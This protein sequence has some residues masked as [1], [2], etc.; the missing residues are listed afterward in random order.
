MTTFSSKHFLVSAL[1]L[2]SRNVLGHEH[3]VPH[4]H[5]VETAAPTMSGSNG[6]GKGM[7]SEKSVKSYGKG[8]GKGFKSSKSEKSKGSKDDKTSKKDDKSFKSDKR[9]KLKKDKDGKL[10]I[11]FPVTPPTPISSDSISSM[12]S[13]FA[14]TYL[15][16]MD[17]TEEDFEELTMVTQKYLE[18]FMMSFFDKTSLTDLDNFL[19]IMTR[20][21]YLG[22]EPFMAIYQSEGRFD[23][24][25]IFIPVDRELDNLI[26]DAIA[27]EEYLEALKDLPRSNPLRGTTSIKLTE[28]GSSTAGDE[29]TGS[30]SETSSI[31]QAGVGAA[32][33]GIVVLAAGLALLKT[34]RPSPDDEN[35]DALSFVPEVSPAEEGTTHVG[36]IGT[37]SADDA[38]FAHWRTAKSYNDGI[39]AGEFQ[40]EPLDG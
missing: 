5:V 39:D 2:I 4:Q 28:P 29:S 9:L 1:L 6:K 10:G 17:L 34:R 38:S 26:Q 11:R 15:P 40:D 12:S 7:K 3:S 18:D 21:N 16:A 13:L 24:D 22:G 36:D 31:V 37:M 19:T 33:A 27:Q 20:E 23:P 35:E 30:S 25:S 32:A 14:I 8:L